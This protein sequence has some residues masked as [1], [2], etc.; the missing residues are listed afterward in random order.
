MIEGGIF[1]KEF[2]SITIG[3]VYA[4]VTSTLFSFVFVL[5]GQ[6]AAGGF[7]LLFGEVWLYI[8]TL[9]AFILGFAI[10]GYIFSKNITFNKKSGWVYSCI[11]AF[12]V[13]FYVSTIGALIGDQLLNGDGMGF[14]E[15]YNHYAYSID[16]NMYYWGLVYSVVLLPLTTVI[17]RYL[18]RLFEFILISIN[19]KS[20]KNFRISK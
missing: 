6:V 15:R 13:T 17:A 11:I 5:F 8:A 12:I 1:M 3:I 19:G 4:I 16:D 14:Y 2:K 7:T 10:L 18:I 9:P 20:F